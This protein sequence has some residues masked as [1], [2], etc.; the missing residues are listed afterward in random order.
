[1]ITV[2]PSPRSVDLLD[3]GGFARAMSSREV[4]FYYG[5]PKTGKS[6]RLLKSVAARDALQKAS[7][8]LVPTVAAGI[9]GQRNAADALV[10]SR[11]GTWHLATPIAGDDNVMERFLDWQLETKKTRRRDSHDEAWDEAVVFVD[12]AQFLSEEQVR[13]LERISDEGLAHVYCYGLRTNWKGAL[14][15]GSRELLARADRLVS[16]EHTFT[17]E[18]E[19][20]ANVPRMAARLDATGKCAHEGEVVA[21]DALYASLCRACW[22]MQSPCRI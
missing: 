17:C 6:E 4:R 15:D 20:C 22:E 19:G 13:Q 2:D 5:P 11:C 18:A 16:L 21:V 1:M 9:Q 3:Q 8:V 12:E 7:L 14:F 10:K